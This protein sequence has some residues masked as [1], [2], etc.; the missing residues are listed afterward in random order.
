[1]KKR[2]AILA[3]ILTALAVVSLVWVVPSILH[4]RSSTLMEASAASLPTCHITYVGGMPQGC[5]PVVTGQ[6]HSSPQPGAPSA[7]AGPLPFSSSSL[8]PIPPEYGFPPTHSLNG[9]P[10][11]SPLPFPTP[12][13]SP[14]EPHMISTSVFTSAILQKA[15][16]LSG[17]DW[18]NVSQAGPIMILTAWVVSPDLSVGT[19]TFEGANTGALV[20]LGPNGRIRVYVVPLGR[21]I[22]VGMKSGNVVMLAGPGYEDWNPSTG[23][24]L[25]AQPDG[26][27][28]PVGQTWPE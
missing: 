25:P 17:P 22:I 14:G 11:A 4:Q 20:A 10:P 15:L 28:L 12:P 21:A 13:Y 9:A 3:S 1:M 27:P 19:G 2:A 7:P 23:Q 16:Q 26:D 5:H 8:V 6:T 18:T 24:V